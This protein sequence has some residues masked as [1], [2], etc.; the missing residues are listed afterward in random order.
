MG[1]PAG[2]LVG[3]NKCSDINIT[4]GHNNSQQH[5]L[6]I[7]STSIMIVIIKIINVHESV[8]NKI[9]NLRNIQQQID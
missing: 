1:Q 8:I 3:I 7:E 4:N 6:A 2:I 5:T 9:I